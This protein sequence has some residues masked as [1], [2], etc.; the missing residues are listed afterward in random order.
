VCFD[1]LYNFFLKHFSFYDEL[2]DIWS[3]NNEGRHVKC[4]LFLSNFNET[5][6]FSTDLRKIPQHQI[7][8]KSVQCAPNCSMWTD[9]HDEANS[10][11][12]QLVHRSRTEYTQN[13]RVYSSN[14][15]S[16][17]VTD[18]TTLPSFEYSRQYRYVGSVLNGGMES[19]WTERVVT[20]LW[21][22]TASPSRNRGTPDPP[23]KI[24]FSDRDLNPNHQGY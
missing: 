19:R 5:W 1:F 24:Q 15:S 11:L 2:S 18:L 16:L 14:G 12:S 6:I 23:K 9:R 21:Q 3:Y 10:R 7:S 20:N 17:F 22:F 8:W 13:S 4:P